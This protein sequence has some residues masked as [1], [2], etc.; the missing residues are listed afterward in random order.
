MWRAGQKLVHPFNPELGVG[1][2]RAVEDRFLM[3]YVP[4]VDKE[5]R[6][7]AERS[8]LKPL[9]LRPG[10]RVE[11]LESAEAGQMAEATDSGD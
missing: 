6:M 4:A 1:M 7:A 2:V 8:G 5:L 10:A 9:V 11:L 3:V